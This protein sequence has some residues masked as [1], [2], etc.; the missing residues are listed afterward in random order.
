M[1]L[2]D[3]VTCD[4][5]GAAWGGC[6]AA[7]VRPR[8][9]M[10]TA[11]WRMRRKRAFLE[12]VQGFLGRKRKFERGKSGHLQVNN[13][14]KSEL[15]T[16]F[17]RPVVTFT[18][19]IRV[20]SAYEKWSRTKAQYSVSRNQRFNSLRS[21]GCNDLTQPPQSLL[22]RWGNHARYGCSGET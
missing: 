6:A 1:A 20:Q 11:E 22:R 16:H 15:C 19:C 8:R 14:E 10:R 13:S 9:M 12:S 7:V 3:A 4:D 5:D 17:S 21:F 18:E 2:V